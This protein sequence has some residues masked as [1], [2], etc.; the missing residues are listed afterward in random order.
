MPS[1]HAPSPPIDVPEGCWVIDDGSEV[2]IGA[3]T[4]SFVP[5]IGF[6]AGLVMFSFIWGFV[7]RFLVEAIFGFLGVPLPGWFPASGLRPSTVSWALHLA[8]WL[9]SFT[10]LALSIW[11]FWCL[12]MAVA[13][14][15]EVTIRGDVGHI[16][17][18]VGPIGFARRF[19][20]RAVR[21]VRV[22]RTSYHDEDGRE[23]PVS[24]LV[25]EADKTHRLGNWLTL[26]RQRFI[27]ARV[28]ELLDR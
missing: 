2:T 21:D 20:V 8:F 10:F 23:V 14:R 6:L 4:A 25:I 24:R 27:R 1:K 5:A 15:I 11:M 17:R 22:E 19:N 3:S 12:G 18:A 13:G 28:L 26:D 9:S 7:S 16:T